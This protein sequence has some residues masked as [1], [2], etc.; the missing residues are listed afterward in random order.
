MMLTQELRPVHPG[1]QL[2]RLTPEAL[3]E[4]QYCSRGVYILWKFVLHKYRHR[5]QF[6][7]NRN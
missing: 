2:L 6:Q 3:K 7:T 5:N 1:K 4:I